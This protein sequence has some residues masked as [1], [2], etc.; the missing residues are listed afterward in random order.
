MRDG[1]YQYPMKALPAYEVWGYPMKLFKAAST[2]VCGYP[3]KALPAYG[4]WGYPMKALRL[5]VW[6]LGT[7][8]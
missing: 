1:F 6:G 5:G 4:V 8:R 7:S 2:G 3:M